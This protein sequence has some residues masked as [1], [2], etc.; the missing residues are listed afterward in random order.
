MLN[1]AHSLLAYAGI[2]RGHDT[3]AGAMADPFCA[4]MVNDLWDL[5]ES[6]LRTFD[7]E[8]AV[9][10]YRTALVTRFENPAIVHQLRQIA[11][12]GS[13]KLRVRIADPILRAR[14]AGGAGDAGLRVI[15]AWIRFVRD[16]L[17]RGH[18]I[19]D[20]A[21][22]ELARRA[23]SEDPIAALL[24]MI[25]SELA[26]DPHSLARVRAQVGEGVAIG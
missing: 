23:A 24:G 14:A 9:D 1:G 8:L 10:A 18:A 13:V 15:A 7:A 21:A 26:D 25:A 6:I 20:V 4:S 17:A 2:L 11:A 19:D 3:V 5:D 12:D 16:E 22:D